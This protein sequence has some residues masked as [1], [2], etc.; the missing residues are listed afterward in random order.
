MCN[1][2]IQIK[3]KKGIKFQLDCSF[4]YKFTQTNKF[5]FLN[6]KPISTFELFGNFTTLGKTIIP[7]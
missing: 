4:I 6:L 3:L 7:Q 1:R 2:K 5:P